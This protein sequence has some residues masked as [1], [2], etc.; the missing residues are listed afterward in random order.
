MDAALALL[1]GLLVFASSGD[2]L[3]PYRW[4]ARPILVFAQEGDP[5]LT[6]QIEAFAEVRD[7]LRERR[8]LV[9]VDINA[10]SALR[11]RFSPDGFT[12]VLVGLD[13]GEKARETGVVPGDVFAGRIDAMP[14]RRRELDTQR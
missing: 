8:N 11:A 13:G 2:T 9:V 1:S 7:G 5:R 12:V 3:D 10:A 6:A 4:Q 14:M